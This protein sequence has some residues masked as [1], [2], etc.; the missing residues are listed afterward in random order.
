MSNPCFYHA[1]AQGARSSSGS[2]SLLFIAK[3]ALG[4][5][6]WEGSPQEWP[7]QKGGDRTGQNLSSKE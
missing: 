6:G 1:G 2:L 7:E 5:E 3:V 4:F